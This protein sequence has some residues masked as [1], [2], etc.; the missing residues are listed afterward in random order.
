LPAKSIAGKASFFSFLNC[1]FIQCHN[2]YFA[3]GYIFPSLTLRETKK[4]LQPLAFNG[5]ES[6]MFFVAVYMS[7]QNPV[8]FSV[9]WDAPA[10]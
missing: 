1:W 4:A 6:L 8:D 7:G 9:L 3:A 2:S 5:L 10:I